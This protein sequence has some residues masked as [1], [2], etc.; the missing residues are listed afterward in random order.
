MG[1]CSYTSTSAIVEE[2]S[3]GEFVFIQP[4]DDDID[5]TKQALMISFG[6]M[7]QVE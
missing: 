2:E 4:D 1:S 3:E 7:E 6:T 5:T